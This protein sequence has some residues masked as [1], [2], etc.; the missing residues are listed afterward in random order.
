MTEDTFE[1]SKYADM[2]EPIMKKITITYSLERKFP[3]ESYGNF[4]PYHSITEEYNAPEDYDVGKEFARL[5]KKIRGEVQEEA[6]RIKEKDLSYVND[7]QIY[8]IGQLTKQIL[9]LDPEFDTTEECKAFHSTC[10]FSLT[11]SNAILFLEH[12]EKCLRKRKEK[13]SQTS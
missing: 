13:Q 4:T 6:Y 12:L 3:I 10:V 5:K 8:Q 7:S 2:S 11:H 9:K 1:D